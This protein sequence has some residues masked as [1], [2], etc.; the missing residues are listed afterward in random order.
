M[1]EHLIQMH[2][3]LFNL[4][5][6]PIPIFTATGSLVFFISVLTNIWSASNQ[7]EDLLRNPI[8]FSSYLFGATESFDFIIIGGG[9]AGLVLSNRLSE[10]GKFTVLVLEAGGKKLLAF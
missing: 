9:S 1:A 3:D 10:N 2:M 4:L 7:F 8:P 6:Y 5:Q